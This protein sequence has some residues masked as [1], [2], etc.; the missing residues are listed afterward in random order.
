MKKRIVK[1]LK[2]RLKQLGYEVT[3]NPIELKG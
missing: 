3:V 2:N 1:S